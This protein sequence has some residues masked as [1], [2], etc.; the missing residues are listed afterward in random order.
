MYGLLL[1]S[2]MESIRSR[3][4]QEKWEQ[5]KNML[6]LELNSFGAFQQ[7]GETLCVRITKLLSETQS[8]STAP[9]SVCVEIG[10]ALNELEILADLGW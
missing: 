1:Q 6:H 3:Y 9:F 4:G 5:I 8:K 7:Y 10:N 2:A